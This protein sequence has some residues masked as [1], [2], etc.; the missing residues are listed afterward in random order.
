MKTKKQTS[1]IIL[2]LVLMLFLS[3][4]NIAQNHYHMSGYMQDQAYINAASIASYDHVS[5]SV[6]MK[7]Q[8]VGM[9][10]APNYQK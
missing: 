4:S 9:S 1:A 10:G 3:K 8:W 6:F 7:K 5:G 2:A